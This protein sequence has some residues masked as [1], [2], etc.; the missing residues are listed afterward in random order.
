MSRYT[1]LQIADTRLAIR[2]SHPAFA[3]SL[4]N[5]CRGFLSDGEPHLWLSLSLDSLPQ[6]ESGGNSGE[7]YPSRFLSIRVIGDGDQGRELKLKVAGPNPA[8]LLWI[9]LQVSLRF[10][11]LA[12][13]PPDILLHAAG[14]IREGSAYLFVGPSGAGKSTVCELSANNGTCT[15][16]HDDVV[17]LTQTED[18]FYAWSTPLSGEMPAES[19]IGA[20]LRAIFSLKQDEVNYAAELSGLQAL[21]VLVAQL[22]PPLGYKGGEI[23][24][25]PAESLKM[26]LAMAGSVPCYELH[27]RH[28]ASF[29]RC[30]EQLPL[31]KC[32]DW[33]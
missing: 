11:I 10:A 17:A 30:I 26:L 25:E 21:N 9:A 24:I 8:D 20:P 14:I 28:E 15:I 16:L 5:R 31:G 1:T 18:G 7:V 6:A 29:W 33:K 23:T 3:R 12:K 22:L 4:S 13:R 19:N 32:R 27:F 2:C